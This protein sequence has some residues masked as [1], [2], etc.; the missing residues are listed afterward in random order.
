MDSI[1]FSTLSDPDSNSNLDC[2]PNGYTVVR[3]TFH[4]QISIPAVWDKNGI[5]IGIRRYESK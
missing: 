4:T 5:R 3:Q 2:K 1:G